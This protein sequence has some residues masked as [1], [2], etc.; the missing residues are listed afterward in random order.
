[1]HEARLRAKRD[2]PGQMPTLRE[3]WTAYRLRLK[4]RRLLWRAFRARH[5]LRRVADRSRRI[6]RGDILAAATVRNEI[7]RL[8]HFLDHYRRLGVDHFLGTSI[9]ECFQRGLSAQRV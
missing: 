6:R 9:F 2:D 7:E 1:M 4:R 3:L 8:P 5:Q